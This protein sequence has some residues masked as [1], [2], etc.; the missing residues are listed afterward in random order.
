MR[1]YL[2]RKFYF[3]KKIEILFTLYQVIFLRKY[4]KKEKDIFNELKKIES[5]SRDDIFKLQTKKLLEF[6][7]YSYSNTR[8]YKKIFDELNIDISTIAS[9]KK[10]PILTKELIRKHE[11][12]LISKKFWKSNLGKR[13]TG[14]STGEPL[15]F[16]ADEMSG[17]H[18][19]AHHR[20]LYSLMGHEKGDI[21]IDSGGTFIPRKLRD[22]NIYWL[23]E[24]KKSVWGEYNFSVLYLTDLNVKYYIEKLISL[25]PSILR[26]YPSFFNKLATFIIKNKIKFN[27]KIKGINLTA[28]IVAFPKNRTL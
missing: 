3:I 5:Y 28:E 12:D 17:H 18:D 19:N 9:I 2:K 21:I 7:N 24:S 16:Y 22:N 11:D 23:K 14:G 4:L 20:Y 15:E 25:K 27:F 1:S 6:L 13:N 10:I 8:Y 26:G